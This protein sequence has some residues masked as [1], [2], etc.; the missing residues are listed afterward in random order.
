MNPAAELS[1]A[2]APHLPRDWIITGYSDQVD[3]APRPVLM[4]WTESVVPGKSLG[5][6]S[7]T[8]RLQLL[9][10]SDSPARVDDRLWPLLM[11][12]LGAL[13]TQSLVTFT[14]A[15]RGVFRD[16]YPCYTLTTT[17]NVGIKD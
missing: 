15:E 13:R 9:V 7:L 10:E 11:E 4:I 12:L 5:L 8:V 3:A 6:L 14:R 16:T 1:A 2:L 17:T